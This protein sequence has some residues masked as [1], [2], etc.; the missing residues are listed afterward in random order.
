VLTLAINNVAQRE[1]A[2]MGFTEDVASARR[3]DPPVDCLW[4]MVSSFPGLSVNL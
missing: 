4:S 3:T 2:T 1:E